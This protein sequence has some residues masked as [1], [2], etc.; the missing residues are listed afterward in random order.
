MR[1]LIFVLFIAPSLAQAQGAGEVAL[2]KAIF[3]EI[4]PR[5]IAE[6]REYCGYIGFDAS[7]ALVASPARAGG[8]GSCLPDDPVNIEVIIA[9]YHSHGGYAPE[10]FSEVPSGDDMEGD[11]DEGVDGWIATPGGRLWYVDTVDMVASQIC[12]PG[13]LPSD[14]AFV[15]TDR[16][17]P[18]YTYD[19]LIEVMNAQY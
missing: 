8:E 10:Y 15:E 14:P 7:G 1:W 13:C 6:D 5:S 17:E 16:V 4:N 11:A 9:S 12:G 18:S 3:A 2:V 19:D